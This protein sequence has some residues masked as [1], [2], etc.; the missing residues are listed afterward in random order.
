M[1]SIFNPTDN[2]GFIERIDKLT[3]L[4]PALWGKMNVAQMLAHCHVPLKLALGDLKLKCSFFGFLFGRIAK[5]K[6]LNDAPFEKNL[7]TFKEAIIKS[8]RNFE[9]EKKF[10]IVLLK[11][12]RLAGPGGMVKDP[13]PFFGKLSP[14]EWDKLNTK[15]LDHHL[16]QFGV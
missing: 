5:K 9:D 12:M 11:R 15:H 14:N 3:P 4:T 6:L 2:D 16:R 1:K 7:P 13:H 8:R 10:L